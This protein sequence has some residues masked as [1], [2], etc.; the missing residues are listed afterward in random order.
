MASQRLD[1]P[2]AMAR[3]L[4]NGNAKLTSPAFSLHLIFAQMPA[5]LEHN[6]LR[7]VCV[8][9][10]HLSPFIFRLI[11]ASAFIVASCRPFT[12]FRPLR[13]SFPAA[14]R[15]TAASRRGQ[16]CLPEGLQELGL[17]GHVAQAVVVRVLA[18]S[19]VRHV[20]VLNQ[21]QQ[22]IRG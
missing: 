10:K 11:T 18:R 22:I 16:G 20:V 9:A 4:V 6:D 15:P 5:F 8:S 7:P 21:R 3:R 19:A 1:T 14:S 2:S 13:Q 12:V 17:V